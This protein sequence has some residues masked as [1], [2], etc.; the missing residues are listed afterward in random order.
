MFTRILVFKSI[1]LINF[2]MV[3]II[4]LGQKYGVKKQW[5]L[6]LPKSILFRRADWP[7]SN[8]IYAPASFSTHF[9]SQLHFKVRL[10]PFPYIFTTPSKETFLA[11]KLENIFIKLIDQIWLFV[12][13]WD[14]GEKH[15]KNIIIV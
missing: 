7:S 11:P 8:T 5:G 10:G 2:N 3:K 9:H 12:K 6:L 13:T 14:A 4:F 15:T 1:I